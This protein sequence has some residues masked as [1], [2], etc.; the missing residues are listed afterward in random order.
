M[1]ANDATLMRIPHN[2]T[3]NQKIISVF[4]FM[5]LDSFHEYQLGFHAEYLRFLNFLAFGLGIVI[6]A[7]ANDHAVH[8]HVVGLTSLNFR[9]ASTIE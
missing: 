2:I 5:A 1:T 9:A 3:T 8:H 7:E 6:S 4:H